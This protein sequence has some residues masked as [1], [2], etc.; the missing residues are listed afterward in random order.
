MTTSFGVP[1]SFRSAYPMTKITLSK[2]SMWSNEKLVACVLTRSRTIDSYCQK[3]G[4]SF[5]MNCRS[6]SVHFFS[7]FSSSPSSKKYFLIYA[8]SLS[9]CQKYA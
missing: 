8:I 6:G 2:I 4:A 7:D 1:I 5:L 3:T 9:V